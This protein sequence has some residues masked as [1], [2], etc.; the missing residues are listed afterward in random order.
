MNHR[1]SLRFIRPQHVI[2]G[3]V[4][5]YYMVE[6][7]WWYKL[8]LQCEPLPCYP[9]EHVPV[10]SNSFLL[11]CTSTLFLFRKSWSYLVMLLTSGLIIN[12]LGLGMLRACAASAGESVLS[13]AALSCWWGITGI[14]QPRNLL[15][16]LLAGVMFGCAVYALLRRFKRAR[17]WGRII[18]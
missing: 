3:V 17:P 6:Y 4:L 9:P 8:N 18:R 5:F 1:A 13:K 15:Q 14:E 10:I 12:D 7:V 16:L 2:F 11:L